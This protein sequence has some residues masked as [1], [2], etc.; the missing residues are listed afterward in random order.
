MYLKIDRPDYIPTRAFLP[1]MKE[2]CS[3]LQ[4]IDYLPKNV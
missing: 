2:K 3:K 4:E 1:R